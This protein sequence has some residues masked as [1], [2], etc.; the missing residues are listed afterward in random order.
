MNNSCFF[1]ELIEKQ[2]GSVS[3]YCSP[4][5]RTEPNLYPQNARIY[6]SQGKKIFYLSGMFHQRW[7]DSQTKLWDDLEYWE[8]KELDIPTIQANFTSKKTR[9]FKVV[10]EVS[11]ARGELQLSLWGRCVEDEARVKGGGS[12]FRIYAACGSFQPFPQVV[13]T[14]LPD[15]QPGAVMSY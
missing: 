9:E 5:T 15:C 12:H 1:H 10:R 8:F 2:P 3:V 11:Q 14:E 6:P 13:F 4:R 7:Q